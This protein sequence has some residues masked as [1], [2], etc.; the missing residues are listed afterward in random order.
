MNFLELAKKRCTTRGFTDKKIPEND[1]N[2][3]LATGR[4]APSACNQQP[5]RIIVVQQPE[6]IH[7]IQ[8]AYKIFGSECVLSVCRDRRNELIS[9]L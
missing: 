3:I 5:Q 8:K 2:Y 9:P 4:V 1:L 7:K 6:N